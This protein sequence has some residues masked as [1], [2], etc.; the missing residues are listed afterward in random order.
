MYI[1]HFVWVADDLFQET[2]RFKTI[3]G[4]KPIF[5]GIHKGRGTHNALLYLAHRC[6]LEVIAKDPEQSVRPWIMGEHPNDAGLI[7][8]AWASEDIERD[9]EKCRGA[10]WSLGKI[11]EGH[12]TRTDSSILRWKLT[13]PD[14]I[15]YNYQPF[16]IQWSS[17]SHPADSLAPDCQLQQITVINSAERLNLF[18]QLLPD[19][20]YLKYQLGEPG[21]ALKVRTGQGVFILRSGTNGISRQSDNPGY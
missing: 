18:S 14:V 16:L 9:R 10:G 6:Y 17:G 15:A 8:W 5:G 12:R 11:E 2:T 3:M 21:L 19:T 20:N 7:H 1:D 13:D 4:V